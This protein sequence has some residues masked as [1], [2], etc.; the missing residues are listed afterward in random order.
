[1]T[2][3]GIGEL[4]S[5]LG[6]LTEY[7]IAF[8]QY[9]AKSEQQDDPAEIMITR[10][11]DLGL[12]TGEAMIALCQ[13]REENAALA[14][15]LCRPFFESS[16]RVL[17][18]S[19]ALPEAPDPWERLQKYWATEELKWA[20]E[21][22]AIDSSKDIAETVRQRNQEILDRTDGKRESLSIPHM[23]G[24][25]DKRDVSDELMPKDGKNADWAY[26]NIYR[27]LCKAAHGHP[28]TIGFYSPGFLL[29][30]AANSFVMATSFLIRAVCHF[31]GG[32]NERAEIVKT[33]E[34]IKAILVG[35]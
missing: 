33:T 32:D 20:D 18:A 31:A 8:G 12:L 2:C 15:T 28:S 3:R 1:M 13:V 14:C 34:R 24:E 11:F 35:Q 30:L 5:C 17:W 23:M 6:L 4:N 22:K 27:Q 19:R 7:G 26:P 29:N 21:A 9:L 25:V 10:A 16:L